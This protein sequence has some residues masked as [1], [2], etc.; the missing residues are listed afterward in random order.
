L[1]TT[2]CCEL[3]DQGIIVPLSFLLDKLTS[4][5]ELS[6]Q[7]I[8]VPLSFLLD[9]LTSCCEL[10]DQGIIVPLSFLLDRLLHVRQALPAGDM[11]LTVEIES[12]KKW[13]TR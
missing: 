3:S 4:C 5:C 8:I 2:S 1:T 13:I 11:P 12:P 7:G 9:K 10:S 6:D